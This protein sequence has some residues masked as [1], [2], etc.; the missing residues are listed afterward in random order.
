ME[1]SANATAGLAGIRPAGIRPSGTRPAPGRHAGPRH[2]QDWL[3]GGRRAQGR[4]AH[5]RRASGPGPSAE[6]A[7]AFARRFAASVGAAAMVAIGLPVAD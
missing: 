5:V 2:P 4:H 3:S 7:H 6:R 1:S